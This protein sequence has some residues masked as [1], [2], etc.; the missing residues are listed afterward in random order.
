MM[1]R[2]RF[3]CACAARFCASVRS[4]S[5]LR[6]S[7][8]DRVD[9]P[10]QVQTS[11]PGSGGFDV[12]QHLAQ[13]RGEAQHARQ[14]AR[15]RGDAK[16]EAIGARAEVLEPDRRRQRAPDQLHRADRFRLPRSPSAA[17]TARRECRSAPHRTDCGART[18]SVFRPACRKTAG[19]AARYPNR[20]CAMIRATPGSRPASRASSKAAPA[21]PC[22]PVSSAAPTAFW[23]KSVAPSDAARSRS[24]VFFFARDD[25]HRQLANPLHLRGA[26]AI[27][28][29]EAVHLR[30]RQI[31]DDDANRRVEQDRLPGGLA[32]GRLPAARTGHVNAGRSTRARCAN[33]HRSTRVASAGRPL[34]RAPARRL[35]R[36]P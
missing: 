29:L 28:Q 19:S 20:R 2:E 33:R 35:L 17:S 27:Q 3:C 23:M 13:P 1:R 26:H 36:V 14:P 31:A 6:R 7:S 9:S 5:A 32:V 24:P 12:L 34:G 4:S 22:A 21:L 15:R 8:S 25:H 16:L 30:H 11:T 10:M 18:K